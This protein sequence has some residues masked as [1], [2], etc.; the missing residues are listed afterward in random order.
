MSVRIVFSLL[1]IATTTATAI[2]QPKPDKDNG[3]PK[4]PVIADLPKT[5]DPS[6]TMPKALATKAT[7]DFSNSSLREVV[8]WLKTS[9]KLA[10]LLDTGALSDAGISAA[11]PVS[12]RLNNE[13]VY[14][15]LNRLRDLGLSWYFEDNILTISTPEVTND[16][17][18]T[19]P[20]NV[21]DL[22]DAG[23]ETDGLMDLIVV[24]ISSDTWENV[25][26]AGAINTLGDVL[27]VRQNR[28]AQ[29]DVQGFLAALRK[30]ARQTFVNDPASHVSLRE[31]LHQNVSVDF[32]ETPLAAAVAQLG[33]AA[34]ADIRL[35]ANALRVANVRQREPISLKLNDRKLK[36]VIRAMLLELDLTYILRDGVLWITTAEEA[37]E[38]LITAV[39]DVRDLC[40][41]DAE[42]TALSDAITS[43]TA[44]ESW[45]DVGGP[46]SIDFGLPGVMVITQEERLHADVLQL[47]E[48]YRT[49]LRESKPRKREED[50]PNKITTVYY[51]TYT[52]VALDLTRLL[53]EIVSPESWQS[54]DR[55]DAAGKIRLVA[56]APEVINVK[57]NSQG[58]KQAPAQQQTVISHS[59]LIIQQT[60]ANHKEIRSV[61]D[62]VE[63]GDQHESP[64]GYDFE[65]NGGL[66]G[67]GFGGGGFGGGFMAVPGG[68]GK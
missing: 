33:A 3:A 35:D 38:S 40:R 23:Y 36:T 34:K 11:E 61:I 63:N 22:L 41:D 67:G 66:G 7:Q 16:K 57:Q 1:L 30:H 13:P 45:D 28:R 50:D 47:L 49:A 53:P 24:S 56:S 18:V 46:G 52:N 4:I 39:Y 31:K 62:R 21:G 32:E 27:F 65:G 25:G 10:V 59:V 20:Y 37:E 14:L 54:K 12:D 6:V 58:K 17:A 55:A 8:A 68:A 26:G 42:S 64:F 15:L 19:L 51:R 9:Q 2:A 48:T 44:P 60:A 43:Q 5:V 29:R